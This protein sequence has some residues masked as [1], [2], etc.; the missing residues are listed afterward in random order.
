MALRYDAAAVLEVMLLSLKENGW[1]NLLIGVLTPPDIT[2]GGIGVAGGVKVWVRGKPAKTEVDVLGIGTGKE[3]AV[4]YE[5]GTKEIV[6][7]QEIQ[8]LPCVPKASRQVLLKV[9]EAANCGPEIQGPLS[10]L[11]EGDYGTMPRG[12]GTLFSG[13]TVI[14]LGAGLGAVGDLALAPAAVGAVALGF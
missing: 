8:A 1:R 3:A 12:W 9:A 14:A 11:E 4:I 5:D 10:L 13:G 7:T 6:Q 2:G